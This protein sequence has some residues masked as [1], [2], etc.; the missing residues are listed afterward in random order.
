MNLLTNIDLFSVGVAAAAIGILGFMVYFSDRKSVTN[1]TFLSFAIVAVAWSAANYASYQTGTE[2]AALWLLRGVLFFAVWYSF[3]LFQ[4]FF[5][6]PRRDVAFPS[7]Y[8]AGLLP[9]VVLVSLFTLSPFVFRGIVAIA[10]AGEV[11]QADV[12]PGIALFGLTVV[13]LIAG[14]LFTLFRRFLGATKDE[15]AQLRYVLAGA[16]ITFALHLAFNFV[17]PAFFDIRR[18]IPLGAV[19]TAPFVACTAYAVFRHH[20]FN[21][22]VIATEIVA[23]FLSVVTLGEVML[24]RETSTLVFRAAIFVATLG[25]SILLIRSV[26]KEVEQREELERLTQELTRKNAELD[27][28]SKFKSQLLSLASH[29][30]K[31]PLAAIKGFISLLGQG[32]YGPV[33]PEQRTTLD[34]VRRSADELIGLIDTLLDLRK[35][36]EGK[37]DYQ[38]TRTNLV[39]LVAD[40]VGGLDP[41]AREKK[42]DLS[43]ATALK[44]CWVSA[45]A[46]KLTQVVR[47]LVD[48]AIKY[49]PAGYV[50]VTLAT[51]ARGVIVTVKDSGL[52]M[53]PETLAVVF[54]EFTRDERVKKQMIRGTGLGLYIAKKIAEAHRG[55]VS[56][57]SEGEG[58]GSA[59]KLLLP[60]AP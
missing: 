19:F 46:E 44:E 8:R 13:L 53:S 17:L 38:F 9:G 42:L 50:H 6:F 20:L 39:P 25:F 57:E 24:S 1:R 27:Q 18:F 31:S 29:Q 32:M 43:F 60:L 3:F 52:G 36:D 16:L 56:A 47:N 41:L 37:M 35:V 26:R 11:P 14:G 54:E 48:N 55:T 4:L 34:K 15:K 40:V 58:K 10:E 21:V 30:I 45:D 22:K 12:A 33:T 28:L 49:T 59:F 23:F 2:L 7:W 5:V 51:S